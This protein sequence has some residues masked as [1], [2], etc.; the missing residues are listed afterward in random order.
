[1]SSSVCNS[2]SHN[3]HHNFPP[4]MSDGRNFTNF[5]SGATLSEQLKASNGIKTNA[6]YR[7]YLTSHADLIIKKNQ[8]DACNQCCNCPAI[9][10]S[11]SANPTAP[12]V[13]NSSSD[14]SRPIG[15][16]DSDLKSAYLSSH[17]LNSRLNTPVITQDEL[18]KNGF[19]N[20][21]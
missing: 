17:V 16:E 7:K 4:L 12:H 2:G 21:N 15:Y 14:P 9:F 5:T 3:V 20:F 10:A 11:T 18:L 13:F 19:A 8:K 1:M 6:E